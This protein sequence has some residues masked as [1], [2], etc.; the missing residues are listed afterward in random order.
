MAVLIFKPL[1]KCN[2]NCVYCDTITKKQEKVMGYDLLELLFK[3]IDEY[4]KSAPGENLVLT[5]HGGEM[6]LLGAE[7]FKKAYEL[8][9][10]ICA[11]TMG[12]ISHEAQSNL[13]L[14]D[15]EIIDVFKLFGMGSFGTSFDPLPGI[16]GY[17]AKRDSKTYNQNFFRGVD[18]LEKNGMGW[19]PIYT[20]H[21]K[22]LD[23]APKVFHYL[24]NL[25]PS[26]PP[27]FN[28]V[29]AY[30]N[31]ESEFAITEEEY[32][33]FLGELFQIYWPH[34]DRFGSVQPFQGYIDNIQ[35]PQSGLV[36]DMMGNCANQ[37]LFVGPE[38]EAGHCGV[39]GDYKQ[40]E[41]G[42][43]QD[44]SFQEILFDPKRDLLK[45][46]QS[47]LPHGECGDCR[48]WRVCHGGCP[49]CA[50]LQHGT[51]LQR[52]PSCVST[53]MFLEKYFEPITGLRF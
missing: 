49:V 53:K 13:T 50:Q 41:Y 5:W 23:C 48:Y 16:R 8:Q 2:S 3:R 25:N 40:F 28:L 24:V 1:E 35:N 10:E 29:R 39:A 30:G 22:A 19:G 32:A 38:G 11:E 20:V 45:Q 37:W 27:K 52:S 43:I 51:P 17:G 46:R 33:D 44:L 15:Q 31:E 6:C 47:E 36:C 34:R 18:L 4:L 7:Y 21:R 12:R 14:I 26:A 42:N 9:R